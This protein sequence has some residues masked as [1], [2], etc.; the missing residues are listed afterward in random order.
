MTHR[1]T[2][3]AML[4]LAT[5]LWLPTPLLADEYP[6]PSTALYDSITQESVWLNTSRPLT[7]NDLKG[8]IIL[9]DF[10][11]FCCINCMHIIPD[12]KYLEETFGDKLTVIGVHSAKFNNE[13]DT[14][15][16][17]NAI[18]R[19]GIEHPVVNDASFHI[20]KDFGIHAWPSL[21][22]ISPNGRMARGYSGEGN[23]DAIEQDIRTLLNTTPPTA[24]ATL[25][26]AL[27]KDKA[28]TSLLSFPGKIE[29]YPDGLLISDSGHHRIVGI[30]TTGKIQL[31][32]G[33]GQ[34]GYKDGN[35]SEA[36]FRRPQGLAYRDHLLYI[37]DTENHVI[38]VAN[39]TTKTVSTIA[40]TGI[41]GM[42]RFAQHAPALHTPIASPW[43]LAFYPDINHLMIAMAGTHQLWRYDIED[44]TL[45][46]VAGNGRESIDDGRYPTN[47]LSQPSGISAY[48]DNL[49]F[50]DSET[51]SLRMLNKD[52]IDTLIGTG[53]FDF[54]YKE[55]NARRALMQHPLGVYAD[56]TGIYIADT[57]NHAIER[58]NL[59]DKTLSH[60]AGN[61]SRGT[62]DGSLQDA[63]FNEPGDIARIADML[64]IADTNNHLI[65]TIDLQTQKVATLVLS[66]GNTTYTRSDALP[67][68]M[69]YTLP[70]LQ[71]GKTVTLTLDLLPGWKINHDAPSYLALFQ[72]ETV[73]QGLDKDT[74]QTSPTQLM[75][76]KPGTYQ[77][78]GTFY[79]CEDKAG[80]ECQIK[81]IN[82]P[83]VVEPKGKT[84]FTLTLREHQ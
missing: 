84:L 55:G 18:L 80:A 58:Y 31:T 20:W 38:R 41:Q 2:L 19:Y 1:L 53:L 77:L 4:C 15:N 39:L 63:R 59:Q 5:L 35:F 10:W 12:L 61:G 28:P 79:Y 46:V 22:L 51:S 3:L 69:H 27:E 57:Y 82:Q 14:E 29:P 26:I 25:P 37:A 23:R 44:K 30:S 13:R 43:D 74:L 81:S 42:E 72:G 6:M 33:N 21:V 47:S 36:Q 40:G 64:Y 50:V 67:N 52:R 83:L 48:E 71:A 16:I 73:I 62:A 9:L 24:T 76:L 60:F 70:T 75:A 78:Q 32:I 56:K 68:T 8:R 54:G 7:S 45:S 49:Y 65:R 17:R 11:T 66:D 34:E